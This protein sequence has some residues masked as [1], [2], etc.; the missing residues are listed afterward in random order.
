[1]CTWEASEAVYISVVRGTWNHHV[2]WPTTWLSGIIFFGRIVAIFFRGL[3]DLGSGT[4]GFFGEQ[5]CF[6]SSDFL[7]FWVTFP[8]WIRSLMSSLRA[9]H[10]LVSFSLPGGSG[11]ISV[12]SSCIFAQGSEAT[13]HRGTQ[14]SRILHDLFS[15]FVKLGWARG[16][17]RVWT[18]LALQSLICLLCQCSFFSGS[19]YTA[20]LATTL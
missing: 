1:M 4:L 2:Q 5:Y 6:L 15:S 18:R 20:S 13:S 9:L 10:L 8:F 19:L 7:T 14:H 12:Y 17:D 11:D 3:P 16:T